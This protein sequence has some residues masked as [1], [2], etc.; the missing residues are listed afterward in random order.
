MA[1]S[2]DSIWNALTAINWLE[3]IKTCAAAGTLVV[4]VLALKNWQRQDKAKREAEYLDA[5][6]EATHTYAAAMNVPVIHLDLILMGVRAHQPLSSLDPVEGAI[7]FIIEDNKRSSRELLNA[8]TEVQP[9]LVQLRFLLEK[10]QVFRF[11]EYGSVGV[12][13]RKLGWQF[14]RL[15]AM[16]AVMDSP[17]WNW[18][19]PEVRS[20]IGSVVKLNSEE[21]QHLIREGKD[22]ILHF[23]ARTYQRLYA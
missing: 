20:R 13:V 17:S 21:V 23:A 9:A 5:L 8:L 22:E 18:E 2:W 10:G 6:I 11:K 1:G 12:A 4:A 7:S 15:M 3:V 14:D 16:M 19:N